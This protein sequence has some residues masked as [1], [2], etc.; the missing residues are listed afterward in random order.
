MCN[1]DY[2]LC[3]ELEKNNVLEAIKRIL[4]KEVDE[5]IINIVIDGLLTYLE[6]G[7]RNN[8]FNTG[9]NNSFA[10]KLIDSGVYDELCSATNKIKSDKVEKKITELLKYFDG[11]LDDNISMI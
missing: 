8:A 7:R 10:T 5:E 3:I 6:I 1:C 9:T 2:S 11:I 4:Q